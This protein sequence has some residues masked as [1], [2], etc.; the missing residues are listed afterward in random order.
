M[1]QTTRSAQSVSPMQACQYTPPAEHVE[2][3]R[4]AMPTF[5]FQIPAGVTPLRTLYKRVLRAME[6]LLARSQGQ[7]QRDYSAT[8][9]AEAA[10]KLKGDREELQALHEKRVEQ[11]QTL[12]DLSAQR[13]AMETLLEYLRDKQGA[14]FFASYRS[15]TKV[16]LLRITLYD[17]LTTQSLV[18]GVEENQVTQLR[19]KFH[20]KTFHGVLGELEGWVCDNQ[21]CMQMDSV[22]VE[23]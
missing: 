9:E 12:R 17:P 2:M 8:L 6:E 14:R 11:G 16:A 1:S 7:P 21:L 19:I 23:I 18:V 22:M 5:D 13:L 15:S 10:A 4:K 20:G 3:L